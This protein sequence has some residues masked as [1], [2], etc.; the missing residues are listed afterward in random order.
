MI[1][2]APAAL[3]PGAAAFYDIRGLEH[4]W[5]R[6][7]DDGRRWYYLDNAYFDAARERFFRVGVEALQAMRGLERPDWTRWKALGLAVRPWQHGG[8]HIVVCRQSGEFLALQGA[9]GWL[10]RTLAA[11]EAR[12]DRPIRVREKGDPRPLAADLAGAWALVTHSSA[13]AVEALLAGVPVF[14]DGPCVARTMGADDLD[15]I[16]HPRRPEGREIWAAALAGLQWTA[17]ELADGTAWRR[18][19]EIW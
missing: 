11:L 9:P 5:R 17:E 4:L 2:G 18:L 14:C 7:I 13:A 10:G 8:A 15:R 3:A 6:A 19:C 16:E 12:T 1:E